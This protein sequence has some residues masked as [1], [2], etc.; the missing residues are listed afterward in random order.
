MKTRGFLTPQRG[1]SVKTRGF[2]TLQSGTSVE[3]RGFLMPESGTSVKTRRFLTPQSGTSVK[4]RGLLMLQRLP[5][6][7]P[8]GF[9]RVPGRNVSS[10]YTSGVDAL[11]LFGSCATPHF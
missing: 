8:G 7:A 3:T 4:T 11:I 6:E 9:P 10:Y 1:T 5:R 2:I